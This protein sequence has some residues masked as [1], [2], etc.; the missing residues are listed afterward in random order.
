VGAVRSSAPLPCWLA[1]VAHV[2]MCGNR[3]FPSRYDCPV[4]HSQRVFAT[5]HPHVPQ[6]AA[7]SQRGQQASRCVAAHVY[8]EKVVFTRGQLVKLTS[9]ARAFVNCARAFLRAFPQKSQS[10]AFYTIYSCKQFHKCY[11]VSDER[12]SCVAIVRTSSLY[13]LRITARQSPCR[14]C[15]TNKILPTS[16][17]IM[18]AVS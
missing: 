12:P 13:K 14:L 4:L 6:P 7:G 17:Q 15:Q 16:A 2:G 8:G 1:S 11:N 10:K 5:E 9:A 3:I 18:F